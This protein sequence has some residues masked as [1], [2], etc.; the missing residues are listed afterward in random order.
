MSRDSVSFIETP[1]EDRI[2]VE[3]VSHSELCNSE[4]DSIS[5]FK[6][7]EATV[8]RNREDPHGI[9]PTIEQAEDIPTMEN[10]PA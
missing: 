6:T 9:F 7:V 8:Q 5:A 3:K 2:G 4:N 1:M 10:T